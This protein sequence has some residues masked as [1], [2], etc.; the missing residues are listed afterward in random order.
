MAIPT[1]WH[2][3]VGRRAGRCIACRNRCHGLDRENRVGLREIAGSR[4]ARLVRPA[5]RSRLGTSRLLLLAPSRIA[6][7]WRRVVQSV[8][9]A[10]V[11]CAGLT[12]FGRHGEATWC[13]QEDTGSARAAFRASGRQLAFR[14]RPQLCERPALLAHIFVRRHRPPASGQNASCGGP[15]YRDC[16][17]PYQLTAGL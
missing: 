9:D 17:K 12:R 8:G 7:V 3:H 5:R 11:L 1:G 10:L 6:Q 2:R 15:V 16:G 4:D 13:G 14:H